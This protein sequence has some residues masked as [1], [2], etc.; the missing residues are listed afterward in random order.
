M[1]KKVLIIISCIFLIIC[2]VSIS[3]SSYVYKTLKH[4]FDYTGEMNLEV[5]NG[6][7]LNSIIDS[8]YKKKQIK[9]AEL[10]KIYIKYKKMNTNIK[11][12]K[13][14]FYND[15]TISKFIGNLNNGIYDEKA[16]I[17]TIPEGY[18]LEQIAK[19]LE[20]KNVISQ[21]E[22]ISECKN[23]T[24][25]SFVNNDKNRKY[26]LEGFLFPDTYSFRKNI[27][28]KEII[29]IMVNNFQ[30]TINDI[31]KKDNKKFTD[32][33][34]DKYITL[35]SIIEKESNNNDDRPKIASVFYN[36]LNT[37]MM[38]QSDV[39]VLYSYGVTN[40]YELSSDGILHNNKLGIKSP[41][42]TYYVKALPEGPICSPGR[43]S[44]EAAINPAKT[45][46]YYF[47]ATKDGVMYS[48]TQK[49][50]EAYVKKYINNK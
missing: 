25:P 4:P 31:Q 42:N 45:S 6:D 20:S 23:Y 34:I 2:I 39:T 26:C 44:I 40:I 33:D 27:K 43:A 8:L 18:N 15:L 1:K 12:G 47:V 36:R 48:K 5:K 37:K 21:A 49:E 11:A 35:A 7:T 29:D 38:L 46:Y 32:S 41:Y 24:L 9:N 30:Y 19:L 16:V 13:Y 3:A 22:F 14:I 10:L 50:H 17:V 28:S